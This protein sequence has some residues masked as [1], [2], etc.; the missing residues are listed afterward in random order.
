MNLEQ[1]VPTVK[2][3]GAWKVTRNPVPYYWSCEACKERAQYMLV[4]S[5][6]ETTAFTSVYLCQDHYDE[7][8]TTPENYE[9]TA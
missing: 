1:F 2:K 8:G 7:A 9:V 5:R 4:K 6:T 3:I